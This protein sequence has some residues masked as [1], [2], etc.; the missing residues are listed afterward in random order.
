MK[1]I[2]RDCLQICLPFRPW[3]LC[4]ALIVIWIACAPARSAETLVLED[5][6]SLKGDGLIVPVS[7]G[8]G[9]THG[10]KAAKLRAGG[11]VV[12]KLAGLDP[13]A[14]PWIRLDSLTTQPLVQPIILN[15]LTLFVGGDRAKDEVCI[16]KVGCF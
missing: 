8:K 15:F 10:G 9:V 5:F 3:R 12:V 11:S 4:V 13:N 1:Q 16:S 2:A 7:Q 14:T 6:E